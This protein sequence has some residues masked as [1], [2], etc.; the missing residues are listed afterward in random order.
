MSNE[1]MKKNNEKMSEWEETMEKA[2]VMLT[3]KFLPEHIK[4]APQAVAI[5]LMGRELGLGM[6]ESFRSINVIQGKPTL[7]VALMLGLAQKKGIIEDMKIEVEPNA[8]NPVKVRC[9]ITRKGQSPHTEEF[10]DEEARAMGL[11]YKDNYKK[12]KFTMYK[13]RATGNCLRVTCGDV[14]HGVYTPEEL[15]AEVEV[16]DGEQVIKELPKPEPVEPETHPPLVDIPPQKA[17]KPAAVSLAQGPMKTA[18]FVKSFE[19]KTARNG[20]TFAWIETDS[21]KGQGE[22]FFTF[23][24]SSMLALKAAQKS[25]EMVEIQYVADKYGAKIYHAEIVGEGVEPLTPEA[26]GSEL[27]IDEEEKF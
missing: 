20:D 13:W 6:M 1:L 24:G 22:K 26:D 9:I 10:G 27:N 3:S 2:Q 8:Q 15:G 19:A 17:A 11:L 16:I 4:T 23:S 7:S 18:V 21:G 12:Q 5:A 25:G 14:L